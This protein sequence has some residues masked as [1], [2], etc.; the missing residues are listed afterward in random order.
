MW[1]TEGEVQ[2]RLLNRQ[3]E[4]DDQCLWRVHGVVWAQLCSFLDVGL[5]H[6]V[7]LRTFHSFANFENVGWAPLG[8]KQDTKKKRILCL[9]N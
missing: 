2:G 3:E 5:A 7:C 1:L 6:I 8:I 4:P 9:V